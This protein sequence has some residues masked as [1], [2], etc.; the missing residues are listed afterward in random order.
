MQRPLRFALFGTGF[1]SRYQLAAWKEVGGVEC[2][3]L[4][5]RTPQRAAALAKAMGVSATAYA[6]PG[7][8]LKD[9]ELDFVDIVTNNETHSELVHLAASQNV[10]VICQKP[11]APSW[12]EAKTM[13]ETC[14]SRSLPFY[15]HENW[16]WQSPIRK[17]KEILSEGGLGPPY[18]ARIRM[19][20]AFPVFDNQPALRTLD[21]FLLLDMG[22]H[23][24]DVARFLF[25]EPVSLYCT[26]SQIQTGIRGEDVATVV[27]TTCSGATITCEMA[28]AGTPLEDDSFPQTFAFIEC[29]YGSVELG[30]DYY[31]RIT[32]KEG[33][34]I[35][36]SPPATF[37]WV[38][39][40]Y[41]VVHASIVP[42]LR[43]L[44][45]GLRGEWEPETTGEDNLKT[46]RLVFASYDSASKNEV[47][48]VNV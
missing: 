34:R 43:D 48:R 23:I 27:L 28:Y 14:G 45:G 21:Q 9:E 33:T 37:R 46:M 30:P 15:I 6:D 1:W 11:M 8:L 36:H 40:C 3:A 19:A 44:L 35:V 17:L 24:L 5:N 20:S 26:T 41:E 13:V 32:T 2:V 29:E 7:D 25:G 16:R 47:I 22:S 4:Y 39:P 12:Q 42:C 10:P 18:R 31:L 38:D